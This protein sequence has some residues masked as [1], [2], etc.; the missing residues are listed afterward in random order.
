M[1]GGLSPKLKKVEDVN[2]IDRFMEVPE[3]NVMCDLLWSDPVSS[4]NGK[5]NNKDIDFT[6]NSKRKCSYYFG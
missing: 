2:S 4:D 3:K 6:H 1:H 5:L